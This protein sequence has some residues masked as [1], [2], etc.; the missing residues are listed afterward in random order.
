MDAKS[1]IIIYR[2]RLSTELLRNTDALFT[3]LGSIKRWHGSNTSAPGFNCVFLYK[4]SRPLYKLDC[5]TP[6][7]E[8][9]YR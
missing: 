7:I 6:Y 2:S 4:M 9:H 5:G 8:N 1:R 3:V